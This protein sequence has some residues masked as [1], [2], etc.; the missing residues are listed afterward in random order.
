MPWYQPMRWAVQ[1]SDSQTWQSWSVDGDRYY[2]PRFQ[3]FDPIWLDEQQFTFQGCDT[4][5]DDKYLGKNCLIRSIH[6]KKCLQAVDLQSDN[7]KEWGNLNSVDCD[8][9][10]P[11]AFNMQLWTMGD[12]D[13]T[14]KFANQPKGSDGY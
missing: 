9:G 10:N 12:Q 4:C 3:P 1:I 11:T 6:S 13:H 8:T 2:T 14:F 5:D 7:P